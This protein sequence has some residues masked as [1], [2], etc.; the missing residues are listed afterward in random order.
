[1]FDIID[2]PTISK[3]PFEN[4]NFKENEKYWSILR[5]K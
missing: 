4:T 2:K 5:E 1:M 3:F